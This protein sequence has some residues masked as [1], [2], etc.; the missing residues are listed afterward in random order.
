V[1]EADARRQRIE[2][3][4]VGKPISAPKLVPGGYPVALLERVETG[5]DAALEEVAAFLRDGAS[6]MFRR[7]HG[8]L[9][10]TAYV[11]CRCDPVGFDVT[12]PLYTVSIQGGAAEHDSGAIKDAFATLVH[13]VAMI[14]QARGV[15]FFME[16]WAVSGV[17]ELPKGSLEHV[18]GRVEVVLVSLET[19]SK[20]WMW[21]GRVTRYAGRGFSI[22]PFVNH[23]EDKRSGRFCGL[24]QPGYNAAKAA[25][26]DEP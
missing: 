26:R 17:S 25:Q 18:P 21:S 13:A 23:G 20:Q 16:A 24:M 22:A 8:S 19:A 7:G 6:E 14:G 2:A 5:D 9:R 3:M 12:D 11:F 4:F 15:A 1:N 10:A